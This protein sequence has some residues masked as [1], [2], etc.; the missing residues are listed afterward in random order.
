[1]TFNQGVRS[2]ILRWITASKQ[3][4]YLSQWLYNPLLNHSIVSSLSQKS[5]SARLLGCKRPPNGS[6]SLPIFAI[7][8]PQRFFIA[9]ALIPLLLL[10]PKKQA[11]RGPRFF[12]ILYG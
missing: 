1:V 2:S 12:V 4:P 6:L 9:A 10:F 8:L 7:Y 5:R 3:I 11:F